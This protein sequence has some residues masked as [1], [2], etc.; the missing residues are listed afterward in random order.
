MICMPASSGAL[1]APG[2][3]LPGQPMMMPA[4]QLWQQN[5]EDGVSISGSVQAPGVLQFEQTVPALPSDEI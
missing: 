3:P 5:I 1:M 2:Q 4:P